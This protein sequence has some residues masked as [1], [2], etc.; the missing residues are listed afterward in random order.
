MAA[1]RPG[2]FAMGC[3]RYFLLTRSREARPSLIFVLLQ[4]EEWWAHGTGRHPGWRN[5]RG[6][7]FTMSVRTRVTLCIKGNVAACLFGIAQSLRLM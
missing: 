7:G 6:R 1:A 3:F 4:E 5:R 2:Y